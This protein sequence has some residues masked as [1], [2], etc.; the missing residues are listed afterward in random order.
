MAEVDIRLTL[1]IDLEDYI[2]DLWDKPLSD[3]VDL[4][5]ASVDSLEMV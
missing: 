4:S 1:R 2:S 5:D 3:L